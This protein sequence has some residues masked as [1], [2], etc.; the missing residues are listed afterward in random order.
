[1]RRAASRLARTRFQNAESWASLSDREVGPSPADATSSE[2]LMRIAWRLREWSAYTKP[3]TIT[4]PKVEKLLVRD[5]P[6]SLLPLVRRLRCRNASDR[7]D[8]GGSIV[9]SPKGLPDRRR[10]ATKAR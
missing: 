9:G 4:T 5:A 3:R 6:A 7:G 2:L 10:S 1:M 8:Q